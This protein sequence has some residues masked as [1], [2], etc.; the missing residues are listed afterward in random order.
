MWCFCLFYDCFALLNNNC[1]LAKKEEKKRKRL[2]LWKCVLECLS[3]KLF[4]LS[5]CLSIYLVIHSL[6]HLSII[7]IGW[8][9][10]WGPWRCSGPSCCAPAIHAVLLRL[11]PSCQPRPLAVAL[12][13]AKR[14]ESARGG[15]GGGTLCRL[16]H[17]RAELFLTLVPCLY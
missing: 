6:I 14:R 9:W 8:W 11:L 5:K 12:E 10:W 2:T 3:L 7:G 4:W 1:N 16:T 13:R 17:T 15:G